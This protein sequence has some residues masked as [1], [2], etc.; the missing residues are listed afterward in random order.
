MLRRPED[1]LTPTFLPGIR[2][3]LPKSFSK[4]RSRVKYEGYIARQE[5]EVAKL[6]GLEDK[7]IPPWLD[8][9]KVPSLRTEARQKLAKIQPA[10]LGQASQDF[11]RLSIRRGILMIWMKQG[12]PASEPGDRLSRSVTMATAMGHNVAICRAQSV[13]C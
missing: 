7:Q 10:T 8:Y 1:Q 5:M 12:P 13:Q 2:T 3:C 11:R 9:A 4:S 6:K